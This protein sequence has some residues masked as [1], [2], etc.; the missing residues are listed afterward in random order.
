MQLKQ[1][2]QGLKQLSPV[3]F[4]QAVKSLWANSKTPYPLKNMVFQDY[5]SRVKIQYGG[6]EMTIGSFPAY[7]S[8]FSDFDYDYIALGNQL[9][10]KWIDYAWRNDTNPRFSLQVCEEPDTWYDLWFDYKDPNLS[11]HKEARL[12][13]TMTQFMLCDEYGQE[14]LS[15]NNWEEMKTAI[16]EKNV[17]QSYYD[18][19]QERRATDVDG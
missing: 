10:D 2:F 16:L 1:L 14:I 4:A 15:T 13:G 3:T 18:N 12:E 5:A 9:G 11:E 8:V 19:E 6:N 7:Q 17:V